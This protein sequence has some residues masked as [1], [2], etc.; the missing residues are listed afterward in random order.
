[1][2]YELVNWYVLLIKLCRNAH[3]CG[4]STCCL[5]SLKFPRSLCQISSAML[6]GIQP[7]AV[8]TGNSV[9]VYLQ[10]FTYNYRIMTNHR[11]CGLLAANDLKKL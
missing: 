7:S 4:I 11:K 3:N 6:F 2:I 8:P 1:M 9:L 5:Y 10:G